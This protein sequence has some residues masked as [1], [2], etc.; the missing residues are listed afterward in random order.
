ME[1][2]EEEIA[3]CGFAGAVET[4]NC[5]EGAAGSHGG[6]VGGGGGGVTLSERYEMGGGGVVVSGLESCRHWRLIILWWRNIGEHE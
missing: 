5:Y 6:E 4:F 3:L 1:T 2:G